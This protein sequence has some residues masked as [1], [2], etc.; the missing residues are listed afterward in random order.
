MCICVFLCNVCVCVCVCVL[1]DKPLVSAHTSVMTYSEEYMTAL[2]QECCVW[3]MHCL[4]YMRQDSILYSMLSWEG[5]GNVR[6]NAWMEQNQTEMEFA[7]TYCLSLLK[8]TA[9]S[10]GLIQKFTAY[11][12][13][14]KLHACIHLLHIEKRHRQWNW[15]FFFYIFPSK[16]K[17]STVNLKDINWLWN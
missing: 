12:K 7:F 10:H 9:P 16:K 3:Y 4:K 1:Q 8:H 15:G 11:S 2:N 14:H 6:S 17:T 13:R 5:P